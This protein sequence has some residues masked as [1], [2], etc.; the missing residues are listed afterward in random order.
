MNEKISSQWATELKTMTSE[1]LYLQTKCCE[2]ERKTDG[3]IMG[4]SK[5]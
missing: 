3:H 4:D 1:L 2:S 5:S